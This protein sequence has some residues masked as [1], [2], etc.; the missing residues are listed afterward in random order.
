MI[1]APRPHE[2]VILSARIVIWC[3]AYN[4]TNNNPVQA[5]KVRAQGGTTEMRAG[6]NRAFEKRK[7]QRVGHFMQAI[8]RK[9]MYF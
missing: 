9:I 8:E 3:G 2:W 1:S 4:S 7:E 5:P 6:V